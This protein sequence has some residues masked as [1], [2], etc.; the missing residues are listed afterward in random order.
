[1]PSLSP[2][3]VDA[4]REAFVRH[5]YE[6]DAVVERMGTAAHA[7]LG[8]NSTVAGA[9][10]LGDATDPLAVLSRL[11]LLQ[12]T[13]PRAALEAALPGLVGPLAAA[14]VLERDG[15]EVRA[16]VDVRPYASDDGASGWVVSDLSPNLDTDVRPIRPDFV[17]GVSS[18]SSTLAQLTLRRPVG[19][20]L[21]LGTGCGVQSL[22]LARHAEAVTATDLNPRA[23]ELAALTAALNAVD[24]DLRLGSLYEPVAGERFDLI[25][26]NPPYVMSPPRSD[27]DRLAYREGSWTSDGLVEQVVRDGVGHLAEDGTLQVLA[28]WAHVRGQDWTERLGGWFA[29]SGCDAHV[30]QREVLDVH[31]YAEL[32]LADAGLAGSPEY[33]PRYAEWLDYFEALGIEAVGMGWLLL[34]RAGHD[35]PRVRLEEW[36]YAVEQPL[37][38]ALER[39]LVAVSLDRSLSDEALL[40]RRWVLAADV[41]EETIGVPGEADPQHLVLRQQRGFRRAT[42]PGTALAGVLGACD[43]DLPLGT[44]VTTV[45]GLLGV[46]AADLTAEVVPAVRRLVVDGFLG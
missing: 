8:R 6:V 11:W 16:A 10:A 23:L 26:T 21:D 34:H 14:G 36:P 39:E 3:H 46:D 20:A 7:A 13:V 25:T 30:V 40:A 38:P 33:L 2:D 41:V 1:M 28:N 44:V 18:A 42:E 43:G 19:R 31:E 27:A 17:L 32:W 24:V 5:R 45:A 35:V 37:A 22:H 9:R 29:G 4:L 12:R 15:E